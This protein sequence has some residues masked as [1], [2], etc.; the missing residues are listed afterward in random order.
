M[1]RRS[2][3]KV[4]RI[5]ESAQ[6]ALFPTGNFGPNLI[7]S[8]MRDRV[9]RP[10]FRAKL[11]SAASRNGQ[12]FGHQTCFI[13]DEKHLPDQVNFN[14]SVTGFTRRGPAG[15]HQGVKVGPCQLSRP[16]ESFDF[17]KGD[18]RIS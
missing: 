2:V 7:S 6:G 12:Y 11:F 3:H 17:L 9:A 14:V 10:A 5:I 18:Q 13:H 8:G 4:N 1:N 16:F 15:S